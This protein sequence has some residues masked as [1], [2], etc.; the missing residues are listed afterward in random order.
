MSLPY[1]RVT[2]EITVDYGSEFQAWEDVT[3]HETP[4]IELL[5]QVIEETF[6]QRHKSN[7]IKFE[8]KS[9][10]YPKG[11]KDAYSS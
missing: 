9:E 2:Y 3:P 6:K 8:K 7:A 4:T 1:K 5:M 11:H 10:V